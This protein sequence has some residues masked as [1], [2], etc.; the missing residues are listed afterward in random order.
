MPPEIENEQI[1][2]MNKEPWHATL[3]PYATLAEALGANRYTSSF[4]RSLNG[5]WKFHWVPRPEERPTD[6]YKVGYDV[7]RWADLPVPSNWQMHGY[8]PPIYTNITY[9]FQPD[10]PKVTSEPPKEYTAYKERDAVGSYVR[11]FEVPSEWGGRRV[12]LSFDGIDAASFIWV[13]GKKVG[14]SNNS[15]NVAEFDVTPYVKPG[16]DNTL[17]VEVYRFSTGSYLEDQDMWRMSGIFR[18][19]TLWSAPT[20]QVRDFHIVT[21]LDSQYKNATLKVTA[22]VRNTAPAP[23]PAAS[24]DVTL[25]DRAGQP[26]AGGA[27]KIA[28]PALPAGKETVVDV[29][30]PVL[31]PLKWTAET[32]NLYTAVLD[33]KTGAQTT[34]LLSSRVG[35]RKV[36]I[37]GRVFMVNGVPVK[38]KGANR[39]ENS[40]ETG[41]YVTEKDMIRDLDLLKQANAN[42]VRTSHY[43]NDP[44]WYELCDE[45]G[46]FLVAEAN[47]ECHGMGSLADEPRM[48]K[49]WIDRNTANVENHKNHPSVVVWSLG[50]EST[51]G[52]NNAAALRAVKAIDPTRPVHYEGFG[53]GPDQPADVDSQM[54]TQ[55]GAVEDIAKSADRTKPFYLCEYAHAMFNS[56]GSLAD[57]TDLFDKYPALM[58]GAIWEWEDQG[59]WNRRDPKKPFLAYGGGFGDFPT[60]RYYIHKGVVFSDRTPKPHYPEV[61][62]AYQWVG[63]QPE[64]LASGKIRIKNKYEF[65]NLDRFTGHWTITGDGKVVQKGALPA[66]ALAPGQEKSITLPIQKFA[67][68]P[69]VEYFL[70]L[71]VTL[72]KDEI[73]AKAG[74]EIANAQFLL[75]VAATAKVADAAT[76]KPV[77]FQS[78]GGNVSVVGEGFTVGFSGANGMLS[79]LALGGVN[80]LLPGGGPKLWLWRAPHQKDDTYVS[81]DWEKI[82]LAEPT[83]KVLA[84]NAAQVAPSIVRVATVIQYAMKGGFSATHTANYTIAGDGTVT[85]DNGVQFQ[86]PE[87]F[88]ARIGVRLRLDKRLDRVEY[89]ARGPME[90]YADRKRGSD[91]GLYSSTVKEQLTPYAKPMDCGNRE[92]M[93]WVALRGANMPTLLAQSEKELLQFS[94]LPYVDEILAPTPYYEDLP[95]TKETVLC[96]S[97]KTL[98]VGSVGCGPPPLPPYRVPSKATDFTYVLRLLPPD[99][100]NVAQVAREL[101]P[102]DRPHPVKGTRNAQGLIELSA[103]GD[104]ITYSMDGVRWTPYTAPFALS[105]PVLLQVRSVA[106]NG[107]VFAGALPFEKFVDRRGWK[108]SASSFQGGEGEARHAIDNDPTTFWHSQYNPHANPPHF[109]V[110]DLGEKMKIKGLTLLPRQDDENGRIK[111]YEVYFSTDQKNWGKPAVTGAFEDNNLQRVIPLKQPA[112]VRYVKFVALDD[113]SRKEL[114]TIADLS[115]VPAD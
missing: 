41:H 42:H 97:S 16:P 60:D 104:K 3:M 80:V 4:A 21:D 92:D 34:E 55:L 75:P 61:K 68:Q 110:I 1:V 79:G 99:A 84:L 26:V 8:G 48:E 37:K 81:N 56:M 78:A 109:L 10:W 43:S 67:P 13:N 70:N 106:K 20:L 45:Y 91:V 5:T 115:V 89:L 39:H 69:G 24:L 66:L 49:M 52:P 30:I 25:Y 54:Y 94:A 71:A 22:K 77:R 72:P 6:F 35:F 83:A 103:D 17:A 113:Y 74:Y 11:K 107:Q 50:N 51:G 112:A 12:Y 85:V 98:G 62:R 28:V 82:G 76:M 31:D 114:A 40:P 29:S 7:S 18:N 87:V 105:R 32:P 15:R 23:S 9:P 57:Y 19:V 36:E 86:G 64:D 100:T 46:I 33:L 38:L 58:G 47:L 101:P 95:P 59:L 96:L 73:W 90:N 111:N 27:G 108:I 65:L 63:F 102:Q 2:S 53:S 14:Y 88:M 93:R 44:R